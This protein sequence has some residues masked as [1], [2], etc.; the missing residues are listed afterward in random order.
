MVNAHAKALTIA[1]IKF[2]QNMA[3]KIRETKRPYDWI[4]TRAFSLPPEITCTKTKIKKPWTFTDVRLLE[5][6]NLVF[7]LKKICPRRRGKTAK[8]QGD[9]VNDPGNSVIKSN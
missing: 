5:I 1:E 9:E 3:V 7:H 8:K 4:Q 2:I 6:V